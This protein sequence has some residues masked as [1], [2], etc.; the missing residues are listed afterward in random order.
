MRGFRYDPGL[1]ELDRLIDRPSAS[2]RPFANFLVTDWFLGLHPLL[3]Y[4]VIG[5]G[6]TIAIVV[7]VGPEA[8]SVAHRRVMM[9]GFEPNETT[10]QWSSPSVYSREG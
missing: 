10:Y 1:I 8:A 4:Y 2:F 5:V 9:P 6:P 3:C 7:H